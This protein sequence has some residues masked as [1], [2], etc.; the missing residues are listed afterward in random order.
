MELPGWDDDVGF[1][2]NKFWTEM[3]LR[4]RRQTASAAT[5][6]AV[7]SLASSSTAAVEDKLDGINPFLDDFLSKT[8]HTA[9]TL[10]NKAEKLIGQLK[11]VLQKKAE[12]DRLKWLV[13]DSFSL[14]DWLDGR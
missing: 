9:Y 5:F 3:L 12:F 1:Q 6:V 4:E 2:V 11:A 13:S 8:D 14:N 10:D 7:L